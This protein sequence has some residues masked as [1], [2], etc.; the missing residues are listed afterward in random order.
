V[1]AIAFFRILVYLK[2]PRQLQSL[3]RVLFVLKNL[4]T[5]WHLFVTETG[6]TRMGSVTV[7]ASVAEHGI[8]S[9]DI[10]MEW[11]M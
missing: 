4:M 9:G 1:T 11:R 10:A 6:N 8:F 2:V 5:D 7:W 3:L